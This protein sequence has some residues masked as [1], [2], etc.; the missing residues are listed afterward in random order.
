MTVCVFCGCTAPANIKFTHPR[1][2]GWRWFTGYMDKT[3]HVC[4]RCDVAQHEK[5]VHLF[6]LSQAIPTPGEKR[7]SVEALVQFVKDVGQS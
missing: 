7:R 6:E 5:V 2:H 3:A 1:L 4:P